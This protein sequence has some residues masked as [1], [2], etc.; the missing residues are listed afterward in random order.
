[1]PRHPRRLQDHGFYHVIARANNRLFVFQSFRDFA[2]FKVLLHR[3]KEEHRFRLFHYCLM[4]N[5]FHLLVQLERANSLP[6]IAQALLFGYSSYYRKRRGYVGHLWQGRYKSPLIEKES[7]LLQCAA[8]IERNPLRAGMVG[9]LSDYPW[10]SYPYYALGRNDSI[11]DKNPL[12]DE[13]FGVLEQE[14]RGRY[15]AFIALEN[16]YESKLDQ[17]LIEACF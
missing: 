10:S 1:M 5:H 15:R 2:F 3:A 8:Y 14:A 11:I 13:H 12:Y 6:R 4:S 17:A 9:N 16:P 7:Y